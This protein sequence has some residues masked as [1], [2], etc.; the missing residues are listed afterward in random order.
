MDIKIAKSAGFC[1]GVQRAIDLAYKSK[2]LPHTYTLGPIIH[3][4]IVIEDLKQKGIYPIDQLND[5]CQNI[6]IR[7]HGVTPEVYSQAKQRNINLLDATCPY[8]K[9]IHTLVGKH[10]NNGKSI[11]LIGNKTH[12]EIIGI[13]GWGHNKCNIIKDIH[14]PILLNL[15]K[16]KQYFVVSQTTYKKEIVEEI[17]NYLYNN[18]FE[19]IH[20]NTIC[21]AT[22]KRQE[23]AK[24]IA[25]EVDIMIVIGSKKS[26]NTKKL[27]EICKD[28]CKNTYFVQSKDELQNYNLGYDKIGITAGASTPASIITEILDYLKIFQEK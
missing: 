2:D 27:Y 24:Q 20:K 25:L 17:L 7:S 19:F 26:S 18:K 10:T 9:K 15:D 14:D 5:N 16:T 12:P 6:I 13:N 23:E 8:V 11:I 3:N 28:V 21:V 4:E 22:T 1:F